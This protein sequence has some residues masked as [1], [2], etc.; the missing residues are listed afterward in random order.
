MSNHQQKAVITDNEMIKTASKLTTSQQI[1][2]LSDRNL[3][4]GAT[5]SIGGDSNPRQ[6]RSTRWVGVDNEKVDPSKPVSI[7]AN[8]P[9][10]TIIDNLALKYMEDQ[11][12]F[13]E[14][15]FYRGVEDNGWH[16]YVL[17]DNDSAVTDKCRGFIMVARDKLID[18]Q[19]IIATADDVTE[20]A[21]LLEKANEL[22]NEELAKYTSFMQNN[23]YDITVRTNRGSAALISK[24]TTVNL[25]IGDEAEK[26]IQAMVE[27]IS[28]EICEEN[29]SLS[30]T[31]Q[32]DQLKVS[33]EYL[34]NLVRYIKTEFGFSPTLGADFEDYKSGILSFVML[35][36]EIPMFQDLISTSGTHLIE[37]MAMHTKDAD[38]K[39]WE[40]VDML[41]NPRPFHE[42]SDVMQWAL[43]N[44]LFESL[45]YFKVLRISPCGQPFAVD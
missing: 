20:N 43:L 25:R 44:T 9:G 10:L 38:L 12:L 41:M 3:I 18:M 34:H 15:F 4:V 45:H 27:Q 42:W 39:V 28:D 13:T 6:T 8:N 30:I 23:F 21:L 26:A 33:D 24:T 22:F 16:D 1:S 19:P 40:T 14:N 35:P 5:A 2:A 37:K 32:V 11:D 7:I 29:G 17:V 36:Q 31:L